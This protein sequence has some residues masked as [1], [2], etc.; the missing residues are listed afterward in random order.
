MTPPGSAAGK[1]LLGWDNEPEDT[2]FLVK[3]VNGLSDL[4]AE[5]LRPR[6]LG[7]DLHEAGPTQHLGGPGVVLSHPGEQR[8]GRFDI[9]ERPERG[10]GE[11]ATLL[12]RVD[13][14]GHLA[15]QLG[16]KAPDRPDEDAVLV[17]RKDRVVGVVPDATVVGVERRPIRRVGAGKRRHLHRPVVVL[18]HEQSVQVVV[19][20]GPEHDCHAPML[21]TDR[22]TAR[23][24]SRYP[25]RRGTIASDASDARNAR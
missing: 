8:P 25:V 20:Q 19:R 14:V 21:P 6:P 9:Q 12:S 5:T 24:R 10:G 13:P 2:G 7:A 4:A 23:S 16:R 22:P 3:P 17:D 18:P 11:P 1:T 15:A